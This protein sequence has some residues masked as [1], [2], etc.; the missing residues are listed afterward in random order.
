MSPFKKPKIFQRPLLRSLSLT[1]AAAFFAQDLSWAGPVS[2]PSA[3]LSRHPELLRITPASGRVHEVH[4]GSKPKLILHIQDAHANPS[5]QKNIASILE[6]LVTRYGLKTVFVEGGTRNN[7]LAY[8]R[9]LAPRALRERVAKKYLNRGEL[10]GDEY[11]TLVSDH[12]LDLWGVEETALYQKGLKRYAE[13]VARREAA[14]AYL[15]E[16]EARAGM[17]KR[18]LYPEDLVAWDDFL[19]AFE[20]KEKDFTEYHARLSEMA[21]RS[22]VNL[23]GYPNFLS[24]RDLKSREAVIDFDRANAESRALAGGGVSGLSAAKLKAQSFTPLS[25]Y[26]AL[27]KEARARGVSPASFENLSRYVDYLRLYST[28]D[29]SRLLVETEAIENA[30]YRRR[31]LSPDAL[32]VRQIDRH[33]KDLKGLFSLQISKEGFE[34]VEASQADIRFHTVVLLAFLNKKLVEYGNEADVVRYV[35]LIEE[36]YAPVA[37]FYRTTELRDEV[38]IRKALDRMDA[39]RIDTAVLITGGYHT[40]NLKRLLRARGVSYAVI[41]PRID[42][43]TDLRRYEEILLDQL[44]ATNPLRKRAAPADQIRFAA[45]RAT[46]PVLAIGTELGARLADL[47]LPPDLMS[48]VLWNRHEEF[49][50]FV[51]TF[52]EAECLKIARAFYEDLRSRGHE[53]YQAAFGPYH[54]SHYAGLYRTHEKIFKGYAER[55]LTILDE[56]KASLVEFSKRFKE[57]ESAGRSHEES[58]GYFRDRIEAYLKPLEALSGDIQKHDK[59]DAWVAVFRDLWSKTYLTAETSRRTLLSIDRALKGDASRS[60]RLDPKE[61]A[62]LARHIKSSDPR[63]MPGLLWKDINEVRHKHE[64]VVSNV[65]HLFRL[66]ESEW[67]RFLETRESKE[68][69]STLEEEKYLAFLSMQNLVKAESAGEQKVLLHAVYA[70][71]FIEIMNAIESPITAYFSEKNPLHG[72][73][74]QFAKVLRPIRRG[75]FR[76]LIDRRAKHK[77]DSAWDVLRTHIGIIKERV[78]ETILS[79]EREPA[80]KR[81]E[82]LAASAG[83]FLT[84]PS[85]SAV[86]RAEGNDPLEMTETVLE[87]SALTAGDAPLSVEAL[88]EKLDDAYL[89]SEYPTRLKEFTALLGKLLMKHAEQGRDEL[90]GYEILA[91]AAGKPIELTIWEKTLLET[92]AAR[93]KPAQDGT[94]PASGSEGARLAIRIDAK[95]SFAKHD[96]GMIQN[97]SAVQRHIE[98]ALMEHHALLLQDEQAGGLNFTGAVPE[99]TLAAIEQ[100]IAEWVSAGAKHIV[101]AGA[102]LDGSAQAALDFLTRSGRANGQLRAAGRPQAHFL[103]TSDTRAVGRMLSGIPDSEK[104]AII[105]VNMGDPAASMEWALRDLQDLS[106]APLLKTENPDAALFNRATAGLWAAGLADPSLVRRVHSGARTIYDEWKALRSEDGIR[107]FSPYIFASHIM[108]M[109]LTGVNV[110]V[111]LMYSTTLRLFAPWLAERF[112]ASVGSSAHNVHFSGEWATGFFH[113]TQQAWRQSRGLNTNRE[114]AGFIGLA[115]LIPAQEGDA[116]VSGPANPVYRGFGYRFFLEIFRKAL[117]VVMGQAKRPMLDAYFQADSPEALGR[118]LQFGQIASAM[119]GRIAHHGQGQARDLGAEIETVS[120]AMSV[121]PALSDQ[122]EREQNILGTEGEGNEL[123]L[124]GI[125]GQ[126]IEDGN[127]EFLEGTL[128]LLGRLKSRVTSNVIKAYRQGTA[129]DHLNA[130]RIRKDMR[131]S[132]KAAELFKDKKRVYAVAIGGSTTGPI[133][134][135]A[136]GLHQGPEIV[137]VHSLDADQMQTI[138]EEID[139]EP[140]PEKIGITVISKSGTNTEPDANGWTIVDALSKRL[141]QARVKANVLFITDPQQGTLVARVRREGWRFLDHPVLIGGRWSMFSNVGL[142]FYFLK[143]GERAALEAAIN[144]VDPA[145]KDKKWD[146]RLEAALKKI[147]I[148]T[149]KAFDPSKQVPIEERRRAIDSL[150]RELSAVPG[151]WE[152]VVDYMANIGMRKDKGELQDMGLERDTEVSVGLTASF[153]ELVSHKNAFHSQIRSESLG[154]PG[155]RQYTTSAW[156]WEAAKTALNRAMHNGRATV[157]LYGESAH[158]ASSLSAAEE[159]RWSTVLHT[160]KATKTP[161]L[162]FRVPSMTEKSLLQLMFMEYLRLAVQAALYQPMEVDSEGQLGVEQTKLVVHAFNHE[163]SRAIKE[164]SSNEAERARLRREGVEI[165]EIAAD[166]VEKVSEVEMNLRD[167]FQ[168][169]E[170]LADY[171]THVLRGSAA[172]PGLFTTETLQKIESLPTGEIPAFLNEFLGRRLGGSSHVSEVF[173]DGRS[174][175]AESR[176]KWLIRATS[177]ESLSNLQSGTANGTSFGVYERLEDGRFS[178]K[179][180]VR[181]QWG[182]DVRAIVSNGIKTQD[183]KLKGDGRAIEIFRPGEDSSIVMAVKGKSLAPAGLSSERPRSYVAFEQE[184]QRLLN[185]SIRFSDAPSADAYLMLNKQGLLATWVTWGEALE[186]SQTF[187]AAS[188]FA[189]VITDGGMRH[190]KDIPITPERVKS[191]DRVYLFAGNPDSVRQIQ[192]FVDYLFIVGPDGKRPVVLDILKALQSLSSSAPAVLKAQAFLWLSYLRAGIDTL[193]AEKLLPEDISKPVHE[194]RRLIASNEANLD[195]PATVSK[196]MG[197]YLSLNLA[198][199]KRRADEF[200]LLGD[201]DVGFRFEPRLREGEEMIEVY[202]LE[203]KFQR[204]SPLDFLQ[205]ILLLGT[206][207]KYRSLVRDLSGAVMHLENVY[208]EE[209]PALEA[210]DGR[211][212]SGARLAGF[213]ESFDEYLDASAGVPPY[214]ADT[215]GLNDP[216]LPPNARD[217]YRRVIDL[218]LHD[219]EITDE[220]TFEEWKKGPH[221]PITGKLV[222]LSLE[223]SSVFYRRNGKVYAH[224]LQW[225]RKNLEENKFDPNVN[226]SGDVSSRLDHIYDT[227]LIYF[228]AP[229]VDI[230]I[231][232]EIKVEEDGNFIQG[233]QDLSKS[234]PRLVLFVDPID[235]SSQVK[236][237][238]TFGLIITVG[239][240]KDGQKLSEFDPATQIL[241]SFDMQFGWPRTVLSF[242]NRAHVKTGKPEVMQF[243]LTGD[244]FKRTIAYEPLDRLE[245]ELVWQGLLPDPV[246]GRGLGFAMGGSFI[247]SLPDDGHREAVKFLMDHYGYHLG[248]TGALVNDIRKLLLMPADRILGICHTYGA[249]AKHPDGRFRL[250][251]ELWH[252]AL[253]FEA[254]GGEVIDGYKPMLQNRMPETNPGGAEKEFYGGSRWVTKLVM[255]WRN[256]LAEAKAKDKHKKFDEEDMRDLWGA[257]IKK[258]RKDTKD[259]VELGVKFSERVARRQPGGALKPLTEAQVREGILR[260]DGGIDTLRT[261]GKLTTSAFYKL[262]PEYKVRPADPSTGAGKG[263][264]L[265]ADSLWRKPVRSAEELR[266]RLIAL[267][268]EK[269]RSSAEEVRELFKYFIITLRDDRS[270]PAAGSTQKLVKDIEERLG[271]LFENGVPETDYGLYRQL[272][273]EIAARVFK[274]KIDRKHFPK[275]RVSWL[276]DFNGRYGKMTAQL[277]GRRPE[278]IMNDLSELRNILRY[279]ITRERQG[280]V[281]RDLFLA[282]LILERVTLDFLR[283]A[284]RLFDRIQLYADHLNTK[285]EEALTTLY[286]AVVLAHLNGNTPRSLLSFAGILQRDDLTYGQFLDLL[287]HLRNIYD[288]TI[289]FHRNYYESAFNTV[290]QDRPFTSFFSRLLEIEEL[291]YF[292]TLISQSQD[293]LHALRRSHP[294]KMHE[295]I[296]AQETPGTGL[297]R[298]PMRSKYKNAANR[299]NDPA[300]AVDHSKRSEWGV[301]SG[302][303]MAIAALGIP[304]PNG[305]Y[306]PAGLSDIFSRDGESRVSFLNQLNKTVNELARDVSRERDRIHEFGSAEHPL[307]L[308]LRTSTAMTVRGF[309]E[310]VTGIGMNRRTA[311]YLAKDPSQAVF[312]YDLH[313]RFLESFGTVVLGL[314]KEDFLR[315]RREEMEKGEAGEDPS[316]LQR[317]TER[318]LAEIFAKYGKTVPED[319]WAQLAQAVEALYGMSDG[320]AWK[321]FR[322]ENRIYGNWPRGLM[323][324]E[325]IFGNRDIRSGAGVVIARQSK[326]GGVELSG[327]WIARG[328]PES[329]VEATETHPQPIALLGK[330]RSETDMPW[331]KIHDQLTAAAVKLVRYFGRSQEIKF[332][333][334]NDR[335]YVLGTRDLAEIEVK[336]LARLADPEKQGINGGK[337]RGVFGGV[338][339]GVVVADPRRL[340][341]PQ[342]LETVADEGLDGVILKA[343]AG[344]SEGEV[345]EAPALIIEGG[346]TSDHASVAKHEKIPAVAVSDPDLFKMIREGDIVTIDGKNGRIYEGRYETQRERQITRVI[347]EVPDLRNVPDGELKGRRVFVRV[348]FNV[349]LSKDGKVK[350]DTRIRAALPT[351]RHLLKKGAKVVLMSHLG[352]PDGKRVE[353]M[354]LKPVAEKLAELLHTH[355]ASVK[356]GPEVIGDQRD[357]MLDAM[358]E[359]D[360]VLLENL[361]FHAEEE[362]DQVEKKKAAFEKKLEKAQTEEEKNAAQTAIQQIESERPLF[363][364][365]NRDFVKALFS[366]A[367]FYVNDAFGTAHRAHASTVFALGSI[368]QAG[369]FLLLEE[370]RRVKGI[371]GHPDRPYVVLLGG[372]KVSDKIEIIRNILDNMVRGDVLVIGGGMAL[373]FL[374][375]EDKH[376]VP[377]DHPLLEKTSFDRVREILKLAKTKGVKVIL[378]VDMML[379]SREVMIAVDDAKK[380]EESAKEAGDPAQIERAQKERKE[381]EDKRKRASLN[382]SGIKAQ[383]H[384]RRFPVIPSGM[385]AVDVGPVTVQ[386]LILPA[387]QSAKTVFMNGPFGAFD[388]I[389]EAKKSTRDVMKEIARRSLYDVENLIGGGDSIN[390]AN[391]LLL[392]GEI[393]EGNLTLSTGGGASMELVGGRTLPGIA[394]LVEAEADRRYR[395]RGAA[396]IADGVTVDFR[397][398]HLREFYATNAVEGL[399]MYPSLWTR[400]YRSFVLPYVPDAEG[401]LARAVDELIG[402]QDE[403]NWAKLGD[404]ERNVE[405]A[406]VLS[407]IPFGV[408]ELVPAQEVLR[409]AADPAAS[410]GARLAALE[411]KNGYTITRK[412]L[413]PGEEFKYFLNAPDGSLAAYLHVI[414]EGD[415]TLNISHV[416]T[417]VPGGGHELLRRFVEDEIGSDPDNKKDFRIS[418]TG[419][420]DDGKRFVEKAGF[421]DSGE[422]T[423]KEADLFLLEQTAR[424]LAGIALIGPDPRTVERLRERFSDEVLIEKVEAHVKK[425]TESARPSARYEIEEREWGGMELH[426]LFAVEGDARRRIAHAIVYEKNSRERSSVHIEWITNSAAQ[427]NHYSDERTPGAGTELMRHL[428]E[429]VYDSFPFTA[430]A[431]GPEGERLLTAAGF[432]H[433]PGEI[434]DKMRLNKEKA[435]MFMLKQTARALTRRTLIGPSAKT[436]AR[437]FVRRGEDLKREIEELNSGRSAVGSAGARLATKASASLAPV[438][439]SGEND[440]S[441]EDLVAGA[442]LAVSLKEAHQAAGTLSGW[443]GLAREEG[444][445]AALMEVL[446]LRS[447]QGVTSDL[448]S[449]LWRNVLEP[450]ARILNEKREELARRSPR[451]TGVTLPPAEAS[452]EKAFIVLAQFYADTYETP[453]AGDAGIRRTIEKILAGFPGTFSVSGGDGL[454]HIL[455]DHTGDPLEEPSGAILTALRSHFPAYKFEVRDT[456][457]DGQPLPWAASGHTVRRLS[458]ILDIPFIS[459]AGS[460]GARLAAGESALAFIEKETDVKF[461]RLLRSAILAAN[462]SALPPLLSTMRSFHPEA[463]ERFKAALNIKLLQGA[464]QTLRKFKKQDRDGIAGAIDRRIK[465]TELPQLDT[466]VELK[467]IQTDIPSARK[468]IDNAIR[469]LDPDHKDQKPV[470]AALEKALQHV[471][472]DRVGQ[473]AQILEGV[474]V[475]LERIDRH[476]AGDIRTALKELTG[477]RLSQREELNSLAKKI[478]EDRRQFATSENVSR[479]IAFLDEDDDELRGAARRILETIGVFTIDIPVEKNPLG[480]RGLDELARQLLTRNSLQKLEDKL[481]ALEVFMKYAPTDVRSRTLTKLSDVMREDVMRADQGRL[482]LSV[483]QTPWHSYLKKEL[484]ELENQEKKETLDKTARGL[485]FS[486]RRFEESLNILSGARLAMEPH[487]YRQRITNL[488]GH[489][490]LNKLVSFG[491]LDFVLKQK[492]PVYR[493]KNF[494]DI[495]EAETSLAFLEAYA[496]RFDASG[497]TPFY[498]SHEKPSMIWHS[499]TSVYGEMYFGKDEVETLD[500]EILARHAGFEEIHRRLKDVTAALRRDLNTFKEEIERNQFDRLD[501]LY[502]Q[503]MSNQKELTTF[504]KSLAG[505]ASQADRGARLAATALSAAP[506]AV[507]EPAGSGL[508]ATRIAAVIA[509]N[510]KLPIAPDLKPAPVLVPVAVGGQPVPIALFSFSAPAPGNVAIQFSQLNSEAAVRA[511]SPN[512]VIFNSNETLTF[513]RGDL[514]RLAQGKADALPASFTA[515]FAPG[516]PSRQFEI[517]ETLPVGFS[518]YISGM[519][520]TAP[521]LKSIMPLQN[522]GLQE[523]FLGGL[524]KNFAGMSG[525][526]TGVFAVNS[527]ILFDDEGN[528][529]VPDLGQ[530]AQILNQALQIHDVK[531]QVVIAVYG[532]GLSASAKDKIGNALKNISVIAPRI[533]FI[534][535]GGDDD[536]I[537]SEGLTKTVQQAILTKLENLN[538]ST[539]IVS[540][541]LAYAST[542]RPNLGARDGV[543]YMEVEEAQNGKTYTSAMFVLMAL[544]LGSDFT[545]Q[546]LPAELRQYLQKLEITVG[547]KKVIVYLMKPMPIVNAAVRMIAAARLATQTSA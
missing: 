222:K 60:A 178:L 67:E 370:L 70:V 305:F 88:K 498:W 532:T 501:T 242:V 499:D 12:A 489:V 62:R 360:I 278:K 528:L 544:S 465:E 85:G 82:R 243:E 491:Y 403:K 127:K 113:S 98:S 285:P 428:L 203:S 230:I 39:D 254:L 515:G 16:I 435:E 328:L 161:F 511:F 132:E 68:F 143:G 314:P 168:M 432:E 172:D 414:W 69:L 7:S 281:I 121:V 411:S 244:V 10:N 236:E 270:A 446:N 401:K 351:I 142:L 22:G 283:P 531:G 93:L 311:E 361:R 293:H 184:I 199:R 44:G 454:F 407:R 344:V 536:S 229:L 329:L 376:S 422:L 107:A 404:H 425:I 134:A 63:G 269:E 104:N 26:E 537:R 138:L 415:G 56:V 359:R 337:S 17:L 48:Q 379:V 216:H 194:A 30:I 146:H 54:E 333:F 272:A 547:G 380:K 405:I 484:R 540:M 193:P 164:R 21:A 92:L 297:K 137:E 71:K 280:G 136:L 429:G 91:K 364:A 476:K 273:A 135:H 385:Q 239:V 3:S 9:P 125:V 397:E 257:F 356:F 207:F 369:G 27:L 208:R 213:G 114:R 141:G 455:M 480:A 238:G 287:E 169:P 154:K 211:A 122:F 312:A 506:P 472:S 90:K 147:D 50:D 485:L 327:D 471:R 74:A 153:E 469:N 217:V 539:D 339:R 307:L 210:A 246:P 13:I 322:E 453:L 123:R 128:R 348:D 179:A 507:P 441:A 533:K 65:R 343:G 245:K 59:S 514:I 276:K 534:V 527:T 131:D 332:V 424:A 103:E 214:V 160:L 253:M 294:E 438:K 341:D 99:E 493:E 102:G 264:R 109:A 288:E 490:V 354:S 187:E 34:R 316:Q 461:L 18:R 148:K 81:W 460:A 87:P 309:P 517:E 252:Y 5:A 95:D 167:S 197:E 301:K 97:Q 42:H 2:L 265:A 64:E 495:R 315:V 262:F 505:D 94:G 35:P 518:S 171:L 31:L 502:T 116:V 450:V 347:G 416:L 418:Y 486:L 325:M 139:A 6:E 77:Q 258:Y 38:F 378:P 174:V 391:E 475:A 221:D 374:T 326:D 189:M 162:S 357:R 282:D 304:T 402:I 186:L 433:V 165:P 20:H 170:D 267:V 520:A 546:S 84:A 448:H 89:L 149:E 451:D 358:Q 52:N 381:A 420:S 58:Y 431:M 80:K 175:A 204:S 353:S 29:F 377:A 176:G 389:D 181:L 33:V 279:T 156:G 111:F 158:A 51:R 173:L 263:A 255:A 383:D 468:R 340:K 79:L 474:I 393:K 473:A 47:H 477:A 335:L 313:S 223:E 248:Y 226:L 25:F 112:N 419:L 466:E 224:S 503:I 543:R 86:P 321:K 430:S 72:D 45:E 177:L 368:R 78:D 365:Q 4:R 209:G 349:P 110:I 513:T 268:E 144:G 150:R 55:S 126:K 231:S 352:R 319:P 240:M 289:T 277:R 182:S 73:K 421:N 274:A 387:L 437:F 459:A 434:P 372:A 427:E 530:A 516:R 237:G 492:D 46:S 538:I 66:P 395:A 57:E 509:P 251:F 463:A 408:G 188:G 483:V 28:V 330:D 452:Y 118:F 37:D 124:T 396:A 106:G 43:E 373:N 75:A 159:A 219:Q 145:E 40:P 409:R 228:T 298:F 390:A 151:A 308:T 439:S 218:Y 8:L 260:W 290:S 140:E 155:V 426:E 445:Q 302:K 481:K 384:T 96:K 157:S 367:E 478:R 318:Y 406:Q 371:T 220:K 363:D 101:F 41:A 259:L 247:D 117:R 119:A 362:R 317:I 436:V 394:A 345:R 49:G 545:T 497:H 23:L 196:L 133:M 76:T 284:D 487:E 457:P 529:V 215:A 166:E 336:R 399:R 541:A 342:V 519:I 212:L 291:N 53:D 410:F 456:L 152:G 83:I 488:L 417:F 331:K 130:D 256:F 303:D 299:P 522:K 464:V 271:E 334:E 423:R 61:G 350:D 232:E 100:K 300:F 324:Q 275:V 11:L 512:N 206:R 510:L 346:E 443:D 249:S 185:T 201:P 323:V 202:R 375:V 442:R 225:L 542:D 180:N 183:F 200:V 523:S 306:I 482:I 412:D 496:D 525:N 400:L 241:G 320:A 524:E 163:V 1:L 250:A 296:R 310:T 286:H 190:V 19:R 32:V 15:A 386:E 521:N 227:L 234:R 266:N 500:R 504:I 508:A 191:A 120:L 198:E 535:V 366:K 458:M 398:D 413:T 447:E 205:A 467:A 295:R 235:G 470:R 462:E 449:R 292:L 440:A 24:L 444:A 338:Y 355:A 261:E 14:L 115:S 129:L 195:K 105:F 479:L 526:Q 192:V 382:Q 108:R 494:S 388:L 233:R 36:L 392:A